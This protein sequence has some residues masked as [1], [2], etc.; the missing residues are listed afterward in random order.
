ME[1]KQDDMIRSR[2]SGLGSALNGNNM[3]H[4]GNSGGIRHLN[5]AQRSFQKPSRKER[6][7]TKKRGG[8]ET[9]SWELDLPKFKVGL[10][11]ARAHPEGPSHLCEESNSRARM[12]SSD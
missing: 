1:I 8:E 2:W 5:K 10:A 3:A 12:S 9:V 11:S 6:R 4:R 7:R